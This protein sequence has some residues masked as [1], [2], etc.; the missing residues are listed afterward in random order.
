MKVIQDSGFAPS[1]IARCDRQIIAVYTSYQKP[2]SRKI[3]SNSDL[4]NNDRNIPYYPECQAYSSLMRFPPNCKF[5]TP[6]RQ[7]FS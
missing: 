5:G 2:M 3:F 7:I 4:P 6:E 1:F